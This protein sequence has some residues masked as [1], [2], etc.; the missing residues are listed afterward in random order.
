MYCPLLSLLRQFNRALFDRHLALYFLIIENIT[1]ILFYWVKGMYIYI[2]TKGYNVRYLCLIWRSQHPWQ[3]N[4]CMVVICL[5][6]LCILYYTYIYLTIFF[7]K[8]VGLTLLKHHPIF[9]ICRV[10][11]LLKNA[12]FFLSFLVFNSIKLDTQATDLIY[13]L[14][15]KNI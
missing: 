6:F 2:K 7:H 13:F 14:K 5:Y 1:S 4:K 3:K 8:L 12:I 11:V 15:I 10:I 9:C